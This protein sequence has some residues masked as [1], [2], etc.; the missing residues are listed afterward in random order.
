METRFYRKK[1]G[2]NES[3]GTTG[4]WALWK[5]EFYDKKYGCNKSLWAASWQNQQNDCAPSKDSDQPGHPPSLISVFAVHSV[6]SWGPK[7]SSCRQR[8][9]WSDGAD[10]QADMSLRWVHGHFVG[11]VMRRLLCLSD[12]L[13]LP[14]SLCHHTTS[15]IACRVTGSRSL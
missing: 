7:L 9:L 11:F 15:Q 12:L 6:G 4:I 10:T 3:L 8:R 14:C 2:C 5:L 1:C 13:C